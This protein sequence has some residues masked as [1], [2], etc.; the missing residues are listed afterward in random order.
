MYM[1]YDPSVDAMA[2]QFTPGGERY[3]KSVEVKPGVIL[4]FDHDGRLLA[5]ELLDASWHIPIEELK[6][7]PSGET[8]LT[9]AEA[10]KESGHSP[11]TLRVLINQGRLKG[12]KKGRDWLV[13]L[14][15]VWNYLESREARGPKT[16]LPRRTREALKRKRAA[17]ASAPRPSRRAKS[18]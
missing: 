13:S 1:H 8:W 12:R 18:V 16:K 10:A 14:T 4:D 7:W 2:I 17:A 3:A 9:L 11:A 15:D 6:T 5:V